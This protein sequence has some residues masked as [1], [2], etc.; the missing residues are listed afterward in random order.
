[1]KKSIFLAIVMAVALAI[2][3][4]CRVAQEDDEIIATTM[5]TTTYAET[6]TAL[7]TITEPTTT[8]PAENLLPTNL[9]QLSAAAQ[10]EYFNLV[11]NRVRDERPGFERRSRLRLVHANNTG[12]PGA[13]APVIQ[14][15]VDALMP[16][17]WNVSTQ[18][19]GADNRTVFFANTPQASLLRPQDIA[20]ITSVPGADGSWTITV[21]IREEVN[22][23]P[24]LASANGRIN[25]ILTPTEVLEKI[26]GVNDAISVDVENVSLRYHDGFASVTVNAQGQVTAASSGFNVDATA[27]GVVVLPL[28][29]NVH[30]SQET[31]MYF[32]NF[33]WR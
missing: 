30:A 33:V 13:F 4:A 26:V 19:P 21:R 12:V 8:E 15:V 18:A 2:L 1:M 16:G 29:T 7:E 32:T 25:H 27:T 22:P 5:A 20:S 23:M 9:N 11:V 31:R 3:P 17:H 10:L 28:R 6:A 14:P 24:G